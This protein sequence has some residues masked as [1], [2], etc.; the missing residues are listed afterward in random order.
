MVPK[1]REDRNGTQKPSVMRDSWMT[2]YIAFPFIELYS[3][4][5]CTSL[6]KILY[7]ISEKILYIFLFLINT[8]LYI[9]KI[10]IDIYLAH[11]LWGI[12]QWIFMY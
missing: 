7:L 11:S 3:L 2:V 4:H 1:S 5:L 6:F 8:Y 10:I 9:M 12:T